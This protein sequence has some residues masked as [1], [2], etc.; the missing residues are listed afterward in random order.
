MTQLYQ[1]PST[2]AGLLQ[3][4]RLKS[5]FSQRELGDIAG[6]PATMISAYERDLRQPTL[7]TLMRLI[8]AAGFELELHLRSLD[9]HD[10]I[11]EKLDAARTAKE[12]E[13]RKL[14]QD[15]WRR[16]IRVEDRSA[17]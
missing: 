2:A 10:E 12:R 3:L 5:G 8:G 1:S 16:A 11:L 6:V 14:Q 15:A 4:A 7:P 17:E 9:Q 13:H